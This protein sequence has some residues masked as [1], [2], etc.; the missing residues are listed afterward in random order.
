MGYTFCNDDLKAY[1]LCK[2]ILFG[3]EKERV[4]GCVNNIGRVDVAV[5]RRKRKRTTL[6]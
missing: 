4:T 2:L 1:S 3:W 5:K 6:E